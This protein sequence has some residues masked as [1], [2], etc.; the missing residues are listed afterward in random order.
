MQI[1]G[2]LL[3]SDV[4]HVVVS[5]CVSEWVEQLVGYLLIVCHVKYL[6]TR[7][8]CDGLLD[9]LLG[10]LLGGMGYLVVYLVASPVGYSVVYLMVYSMD[11]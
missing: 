3:I 7:V 1:V 4:F 8:G 2:H 6:V 11:F 10:G 9:G 5:C